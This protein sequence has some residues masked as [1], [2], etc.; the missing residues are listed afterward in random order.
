MRFLPVL[1]LSIGLL[2]V[3]M[4]MAGD[5]DKGLQVLRSIGLVIAGMT[6]MALLFALIANARS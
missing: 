3:V 5:K 2:L 6:L 1:L 4:V